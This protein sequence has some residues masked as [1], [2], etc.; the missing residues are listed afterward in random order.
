MAAQYFRN[1]GWSDEIDIGQGTDA[2]SGRSPGKEITALNHFSTLHRAAALDSLENLVMGSLGACTP[3]VRWYR[4]LETLLM[5]VRPLSA[6]NERDMVYSVLGLASKALP[7]GMRTPITPQVWSFCCGDIHIN[8]GKSV[9][10]LANAVNSISNGRQQSAN[11][12]RI[13]IMGP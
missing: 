4:Y 9:A 1:A 8:N 2:P 5:Q 10:E 12:S 7:Y 6:S 3:T 11:S 13:A